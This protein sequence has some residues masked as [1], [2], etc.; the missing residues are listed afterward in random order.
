MKQVALSNYKKAVSKDLLSVD[1]AISKGAFL[2]A[3][4][5]FDFNFKSAILG[6]NSKN[7]LKY[8]LFNNKLYKFAEASAEAFL[9]LV[10]IS[11]NGFCNSSYIQYVERVVARMNKF[12]SS[13]KRISVEGFDKDGTLYIKVISCHKSSTTC[14]ITGI[15]DALKCLKTIVRYCT[16]NADCF[17][18]NGEFGK[19][20]NGYIGREFTKLSTN[21]APTPYMCGNDRLTLA[22]QILGSKT[23]RIVGATCSGGKVIS[24]V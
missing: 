14:P 2:S 13:A 12:L 5:W 9:Y 15:E 24:I 17:T 3:E 19:F 18:H 22:K 20:I 7:I 16:E 11:V 6:F 4:E 1:T 10:D 23:N 21:V 8:R